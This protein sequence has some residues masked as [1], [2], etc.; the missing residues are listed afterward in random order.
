MLENV[1]RNYFLVLFIVMVCLL[2]L[3]LYLSNVCGINSSVKCWLIND[4]PK[5][6]PKFMV[7]NIKKMPE[8]I[9]TKLSDFKLASQLE[10]LKQWEDDYFSKVLKYPQVTVLVLKANPNDPISNTPIDKAFNWTGSKLM[11][12]NLQ[13]PPKKNF[14]HL[15]NKSCTTDLSAAFKPIKLEEFYFKNPERLDSNRRPGVATFLTKVSRGLITAEFGHVISAN[16]KIVATQ[17][18]Y[19]DLGEHPPANLKP[20]TNVED[21]V[22][23]LSQFWGNNI[24]HSMMEEFTRASFYINFLKKHKDVKIHIYNVGI[25]K[26][27]LKHLGI[28]PS[29]IVTGHVWAKTIYL[30]EGTTC[31]RARPIHAQFLSKH[32]RQQI[33]EKFRQNERNSVVLIKRNPGALRHYSHHTELQNFMEK[34]V[35]ALGFRFELFTDSPLPSFNDIAAMFNRAVMVVAPHGAGLSNMLFSKPGTFIVELVC[36]WIHINFCY[37][38]AAHILG[39]RW[40][41][42]SGVSGCEGVIDL[43]TDEIEKSIKFYLTWIKEHRKEWEKSVAPPNKKYHLTWKIEH[44]G[45]LTFTDFIE[46]TDDWLK[47][48]QP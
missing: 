6:R 32:L 44:I 5:P 40:H 1:R 42:I 48:L 9:P 12:K 18:N 4:A 16:V 10:V 41:G 3:M 36:N 45:N 15:Y 11:C 47:T 35:P 20:P 24:F 33:D 29:R 17:C 38:N 34:F 25:V 13:D 23:V 37:Q 26:N 30:P 28:D 19:P 31:G 14:L 46:N 21:T 7:N 8:Y 43:P 39:H 2:V 22:F 27:I